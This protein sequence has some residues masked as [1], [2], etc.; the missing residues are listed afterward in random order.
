MNTVTLKQCKKQRKISM[1]TCYD[2]PSARIIDD[3]TIDC[4]L[5]GDSVAMTVHGHQ[6]TTQATIDMMTL[7][8]AAVRRGTTKFII[9]DM[10]FMSYRKSKDSVLHNVEKLIKAGA[11][12]V[13]IEGAH[14]NLDTIK[15]IVYSGVPVVGHIG[16]IP[17]H[18]NALGGFR[19]QG[20]TDSTKSQLITEAK[21]LQETGCFMLV[22]ECIP[23]DLAA[24]ITEQL[25][26][27]TIGIGAGPT[28]D[29]QVLVWH[30]VLGMQADTQLKFLKQYTNSYEQIHRAITSYDQDVK[31]E[32]FPTLEHSF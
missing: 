26:I 22:L 18:V 12:A 27:P 8:T 7:H 9:S 16:L 17:Q 1:I 5:V 28:T 25:D 3:T 30:D 24:T 15:H 19:V 14:G 6:D 4:I 23:S 2:Y 13:K 10:P 11:N 32:V 21:Q 20:K 31:T 29:G